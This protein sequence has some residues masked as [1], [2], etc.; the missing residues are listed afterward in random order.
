MLKQRDSGKQLDVIIL[1]FSKAFDTVPHSRLLGKLHHYG[2][3]GNLLRW[4][5]E[6]LVG[7]TQ[8][9]L[10]DGT[11]S[12][13]ETVL[14]GFPQGTVLEP[15]TFLLYINDMPSQVQRDTRCRLF[16]D[17]SLL[18]RVIDLTLD[19]VQLQQ[20]LKN[21][22]KW[23]LDWG[24][25]FNPSKCYVMHINGGRTRRPYL[26]QLC[27]VLLKSVTQERYL[28]VI[29]TQSLS[30][31][32]H[33]SQVSVK[34]N[35]KLGIIKRNLKGSPQELKRLAYITL[36]RSGM[37]YASPVWEPSTS[38]DQDTLERVQMRAARWIT[39]SYDRTTSVTKLLRQLN[40]EPLDKRRRI[41]RLTFLYKVLNEHVAVPPDKLDIKE[42]GRPVRGSVTKQRLVIPR[43]STNELKNSFVPRTIVQWN[44]LPD[45][46]TS[47]AS[48]NA[49]RSQL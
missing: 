39:S 29:L 3:K 17:D 43:C 32:N 20:D 27:G 40:L 5:E 36:V 49:F 2:I 28:G 13:E 46:N 38:K 25:V 9:V 16:A 23:A 42:N 8:S 45:S 34:A 30:W 18:Y 12:P 31:S 35:Q 26:Y 33:I 19:Q 10:V 11:K 14:S 6:F 22:E 24:M 37:E 47:A 4:I 1:D 41:Y 7:R 48:V 15:L 21:L 44:A